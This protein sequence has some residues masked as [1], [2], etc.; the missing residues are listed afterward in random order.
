MSVLRPCEDEGCNGMIVVGMYD[1]INVPKLDE[2]GA[3]VVGRDGQPER[4]RLRLPWHAVRAQS[5]FDLTGLVPAPCRHGLAEHPDPDVMKSPHARQAVSWIRSKYV[6]VRKGPTGLPI[7]GCPPCN[8]EPRPADLTDA[9]DGSPVGESLLDR[10]ARQ[11]A[12]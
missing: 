1:T 8:G 2:D 7:P 12:T 9:R 3:P 4:V 6:G 11:A 10:M 5:K